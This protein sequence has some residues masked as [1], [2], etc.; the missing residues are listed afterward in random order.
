MRRKAEKKK[1]ELHQPQYGP[2]LGKAWD[3]LRLCWLSSR[4]PRILGMHGA[5][6]P[7]LWVPGTGSTRLG[8]IHDCRLFEFQDPQMVFLFYRS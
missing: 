7:P 1:D 3:G 4:D 8:Q 5:K 2:L 6:T